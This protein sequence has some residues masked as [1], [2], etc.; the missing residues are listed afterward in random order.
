M[1][2]DTGD[3]MDRVMQNAAAN[4][5]ANALILQAAHKAK[6]SIANPYPHNN[7][8]KPGEWPKARTFNLRD[9]VD[10]EP[11]SVAEIMNRG[12]IRVGVLKGA[13]YGYFLTLPRF[14]RKGIADTH[15]ELIGTG[16]Y[17]VG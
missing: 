6:L 10:I 2:F 4:L 7:P 14:G 8:S 16:G 13:E 9:A 15:A 3:V 17:R 1:A 11:R 5:L 12:W